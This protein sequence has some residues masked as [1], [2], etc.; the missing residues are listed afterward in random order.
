[1]GSL[2]ELIQGRWLK[3][4]EKRVQHLE[5]ELGR[6][7]TEV[8]IT[9]VHGTF[10][11]PSVWRSTIPALE[12]QLR[13][14]SLIPTFHFFSWSGDNTHS[15][16]L[17]ASKKLKIELT[18]QY[19][20]NHASRQFVVAHS[21]GGTMA[22]YTLRDD[23]L[24]SNTEGLITL[25]TPVINVEHRDLE[26]VKRASIYS[27]LLIFFMLVVLSNIGEHYYALGALLAYLSTL[28]FFWALTRHLL[29]SR[30]FNSSRM[31][32]PDSIFPISKFIEEFW[33]EVDYIQKRYMDR[34]RHLGLTQI[35][36]LVIRARFDE[37]LI[38]LTLLHAIGIISHLILRIFLM[39]FFK[40]FAMI[41]I[42]PS[43]LFSLS[44]YPWLSILFFL[45]I[46]VLFS[47]IILSSVLTRKSK[48]SF[49]EDDLL[50]SLLCKISVT[51]DADNFWLWQQEFISSLS[52]RRSLR[53]SLFFD[54]K[55]VVDV[56]CS[57][58]HKPSKRKIS[59]SIR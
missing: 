58:I 2:P 44:E 52:P 59:F 30:K 1:M 23:F 6:G 45:V 4:P 49:G 55:K 19:R 40:P 9:L 39:V 21:H 15:A 25:G 32:L 3:G 51:G 54:N 50:G 29:S 7:P 31:D 18:E 48:W 53:H 47:G 34:L 56:I 13:K 20:E 10:S 36:C 24:K 17:E 22:A 28:T 5:E 42:W 14:R 12:K 41:F 27:L 33:G 38:W 26:L 37:A 57:W 16:R 43:F 35:H 11:D 46:S 8:S